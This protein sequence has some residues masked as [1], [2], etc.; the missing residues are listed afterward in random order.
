MP[1]SCEVAT[2]QRPGRTTMCDLNPKTSEKVCLDCCIG[3][4]PPHIHG[5]RQEGVE[6]A[7]L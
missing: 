6:G 2:G 1:H 3:L 7:P 5:H 4:I